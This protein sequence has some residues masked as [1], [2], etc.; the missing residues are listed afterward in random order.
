VGLVNNPILI[1]NLTNGVPDTSTLLVIPNAPN[2]SAYENLRGISWD[3]ADN[4][5]TVS[6][7]QGLLRVFS[8]SLPATCITS[9]DYTGT[10]GSFQLILPNT[11]ASVLATTALA[12]QNHGSPTPGVFT[13]TLNTNFLASPVTVNFTL[14]GTATNGTYIASATNSVTF[15][16]GTSPSGN[17]STNV[18]ITPTV[19][20]VIGPT[21]SVTLTVVGGVTYLAASP[22]QAT[23]Y[24]ANTGPQ[25]FSVTSVSASTMYRGLTSDF[26]AFVITRLGDT[27]VGPVTVTNFTYGGTAVFGVDYLAGAQLEASGY[28]V[29]GSPGVVFNP[30]DVSKTVIVGAP[31]PT[32]YGSAA[33]GNK[34]V[35]VGLGSSSSNY[36]SQE[37]VSY[38]V[39]SATA[40]LTEIDNAYPPEVVYWSNPMT[41]AG[42]TNWTLTFARTNLDV[43]G[44]TAPPVIISPYTTNNGGGPN[45]LSDNGG[46]NDFD[47]EFGYAISAD[48]IGQ[49]LAMAA[50]GWTNALKMTVNK[51]T[52]VPGASSGVNVYPTGMKF[53][54][55]YSLRFNMN[56]VEGSGYTGTFLSEAVEFGINHGGTNCN[57]VSA[58]TTAF[59]TNIDGVWIAIDSG[60][61]LSAGTPPDFGLY[62]GGTSAL[63]TLPNNSWYQPVSDPGTAEAAVFKHPTPYDATGSGTPAYSSAYLPDNI[64]SDVELAQYNGTVTL[65]VNKTALLTY[66][67]T[68]QFTN[69]DIMLGYDD[70]YANVSAGSGAA[71]YI[72]N[73]RV[74]ENAPFITSFAP[75]NLTIFQGQSASFT[76]T[77][78][79]TPPFTNVWYFGT[80]PI[81][82]NI[83]STTGD[84]NTLLLNNVPPASMGSYDVVISDLSGGS[85]TS[86]VASLTVIPPSP[87]FIGSALTTNASAVV[88]MFTTADVSASTNTFT[89]QVS[90]NLASTVN[91]GF[92]KVTNAVFS[93]SN[94]IYKVQ[95]P[96]NGPAAFYRLIQA[97]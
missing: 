76:V 67:V 18:T 93:V 13:I 60:A 42:D 51:D 5:Y 75:T 48:S 55:N 69:G 52:F 46:T 39:G 8:L 36:T 12:S 94:G 83:V 23:V 96:T 87:T 66:A 27:N 91:S 28:P 15:P 90:T 41:N 72:S 86:S 79:G 19:T 2:T 30:S 68:N 74:V 78:T 40:S 47:V 11:T 80:T 20:P 77:A 70:P 89:L 71:A 81:V 22:V 43:G 6:S 45:Y 37:G 97:E 44:V 49:S 63:Q 58:D 54:G 73:V 56:L 31:V 9:N 24:I 34:S 92:V 57:W 7:G 85:V 61:G 16:A 95:A 62:T 32:P 53:G 88:L 38:T 50:N 17:W 21:I 29:A 65:Y 10:N 26:G 59:Y 33:V 1:L 3:A 35:I 82:T 4:V 25:Y 14:G 84:T 64:W